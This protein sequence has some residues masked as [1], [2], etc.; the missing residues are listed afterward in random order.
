MLSNHN[1]IKLKINKTHY[2][3]PHT[4]S[5]EYTSTHTG[6]F[7]EHSHQDICGSF[8]IEFLNFCYMLLFFI[9]VREGRNKDLIV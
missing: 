8:S 6:C 1:T 5:L 7:R 3:S 2:I 9:Y 4:K